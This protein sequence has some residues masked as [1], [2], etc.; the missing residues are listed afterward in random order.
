[1]TESDF[2][3]LIQKAFEQSVHKT[4]Q[5]LVDCYRRAH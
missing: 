2:S 5:I 4:I 3:A 1:M